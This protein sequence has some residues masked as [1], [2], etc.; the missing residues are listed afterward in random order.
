VGPLTKLQTTV[1][2]A[3]LAIL[4]VL[5][6]TAEPGI[7]ANIGFRH[8]LSRLQL[9]LPRCERGHGLDANGMVPDSNAAE[10]QRATSLH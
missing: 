7:A 4:N 5:N 2:E 1:A 9:K 8:P 3:T 10:Y 6:V